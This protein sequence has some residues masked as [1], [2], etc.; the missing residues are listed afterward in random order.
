MPSQD[1]YLD[2]LLKDLNNEEAGGQ[3]GEKEKT[4]DAAQIDMSDIEALLQSVPGP[5]R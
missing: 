4:E 1:D 3:T 2:S 5:E